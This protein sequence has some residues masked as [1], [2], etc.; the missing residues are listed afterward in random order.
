MSSLPIDPDV[1]NIATQWGLDETLLQAVVDAEGN[2]LR[3]VQCSIPS[4]QTREE[5]LKVVA[6]S[7]THALSDYVRENCGKP[8]VQFWAERWAPQGATNDP[9]NL[10]ANWPINVSKF[11][12]V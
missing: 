2:I 8:F 9:K 6:R 4:I 10:N 3:A 12:G 7:A 5:A 11:W 1:H